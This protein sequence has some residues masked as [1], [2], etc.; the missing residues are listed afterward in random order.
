MDRAIDKENV[1]NR[2]II[3]GEW[4]NNAQLRDLEIINI[5]PNRN[6]INV[7]DKFKQY[8]NTVGAVEWQED[9]I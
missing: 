4:R 1:E 7:R 5:R 9:M 2:T 3:P 6:T 8:L